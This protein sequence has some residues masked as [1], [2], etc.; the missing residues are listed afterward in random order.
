VV[1]ALGTLL[2]A[3]AWLRCGALPEGL[4]DSATH[5][6]TLIV[7]RNGV[8]LYESLSDRDA[9]SRWIDAEKLPANV[10]KATL[11]A[12]DR[13]FFR[14]PGI[15]P[16][17]I[18]RAAWSNARHRGVVQG[19]STITQ[20]VAKQ[21]SPRQR[22]LRGKFGEMVLAL[23]MEHHLTKNEI[24]ALYLNLAPYGNQYIG[25]DRASRG[26]FGIAPSQ[27][28]IA[29][30]AYL[31]GLPQRPSRLNPRRGNAGLK[32]QRVVLQRMHAAGL[33]TSDEQA[34]A[35]K[36]RLQFTA[37]DRDDLAPH[38]VERVLA[39][40][41]GK[42]P[43]FIRT[44]L[45]AD[46]QRKVRGIIESH[47]RLLARHG[48]KNVAVVVLDNRTGG[49]LAWEGSGDYFDERREGAI[50]GAITPRQPG[51]ALKPFTYA[52]AFERG[53]SPATVLP[54]IPSHYPTAEE[55][56]VYSPRNYDG[57]FRGPLRARAALAGSENVPAV[58]LLSRHSPAELLRFLRRM[59]LTTFDRTGDY[60]GLGLTLGDAEVRLDELVAAYAVFARGGTR[61]NGD[62]IVSPR[63]AFWITDIL[64]DRKARAF[65]FG[66]WSNLDLPFPVA[67]KTG[68]SQ[69][70][71]DNWTI[72]YTS[73]VTVGVWV[74]NFD[75]TE[76]KN[77][78]G[79]TGAAPIF[80]AVMMAAQER[81]T[82]AHP[83]RPIL[84][85]T[86]D[87]ERREICSLSGQRP[88]AACMV[89]EKEWLPVDQTGEHCT[90]HRPGWVDWPPQYRAWARERNLLKPIRLAANREREGPAPRTL[91][92]V[93]PP[94]GATYLIDPTL[95][96]THQTLSLRAAADG[97][98]PIRWNVNG[99]PVGT[100]R[101]D[102]SL[103]W[104]IRPG[105]HRISASDARSRS[106]AVT[107]V[108]K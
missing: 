40:F 104:P 6:S 44:T 65:A 9:R 59:R 39:H 79:V 27:L 72:G 8:P 77:S 84:E 20:Q 22:T 17:A 71:R 87:L 94:D 56:I 30:S 102:G 85:P 53:L 25:I 69:A 26:Y 18:G 63:T 108:V 51:S 75:R 92:I 48:A 99:Q 47:S 29:Q 62:R 52:L 4:L 33:I 70:Y 19:G 96:S 21:L 78:S 2:A 54:D 36:E 5:Q 61:F 100:S 24:L 50:D 89:V 55:G 81:A 28:T 98:G 90:W 106:D 23:R 73:E 49:W 42:P 14:H 35:Q 103:A 41:A 66:E 105:K 38:F 3:A 76:L 13:R 68:T 101:P 86:G 88:N 67:A 31:A 32:R 45:D 12:E 37:D 95:R 97:T 60:Y 74:G 46:L 34:I 91:Q 57:V 11:A 15:D 7:D 43:R 107:I 64:S 10:V 82:G 93:N 80:N 83:G 16:L 1:A 58:W